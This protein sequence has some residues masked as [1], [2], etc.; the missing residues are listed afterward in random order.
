MRCEQ[1]AVPMDEGCPPCSEEGRWTEKGL[2]WVGS[3][4][5]QEKNNCNI[6]KDSELSHFQ[7]VFPPQTGPSPR[8]IANPEIGQNGVF[9]NWLN[10]LNFVIGYDDKESRVGFTPVIMFPLVKKSHEWIWLLSI[11]A[12]EYSI[13]HCLA[14]SDRC[15]L[16]I[17]CQ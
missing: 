5:I 6:K 14:K 9:W 2:R 10:C 15:R 17:D 8:R 13:R 3:K 11:N 7:N 1:R 4:S 16:F 12:P